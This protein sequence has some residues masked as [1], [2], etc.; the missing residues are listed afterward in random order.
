MVFGRRREE[1]AREEASRARSA[2][3]VAYVTLEQQW[4]TTG[5]EAQL[6]RGTLAPYDPYGQ[7]LEAEHQRTSAQL[8]ATT[9]AFLAAEQLHAPEAL[10]GRQALAE[11][12]ARWQSVHAQI[13]ATQQMV[14]GVVQLLGDIDVRRRW[15]EDVVPQLQTSLQDAAGAVTAAMDR[16]FRTADLEAVLTRSR[17]AAEEGARCLEQGRLWDAYDALG[18]AHADVGWV[19]STAWGLSRRHRELLARHAALTTRLADADR[20]AQ[21]AATTVNALRARY[22]ATVHQPVEQAPEQA[23]EAVEDARGALAEAAQ[24][25]SLEVQAY[26]DADA[27]LTRAETAIELVTDIAA[28]VAA[29]EEDV[30]AAVAEFPA[31]HAEAARD[32]AQAQAFVE[33]YAGHLDPSL[34]AA[35]VQAANVLADAER[36]GAAGRGDPF[37]VLQRLREVEG[38]S[39]QVLDVARTDVQRREA[40][41]HHARGAIRQA[42]R[43]VNRARSAAGLGLLGWKAQAKTAV[44]DA[45]RVLA[46]A[47]AVVQHDPARAERLAAEAAG[48]ATQVLTEDHRRRYGRPPPFL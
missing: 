25:A 13:A 9:S 14:Q 48:I 17:D 31:V 18:R 40:H 41:R 26:D 46:E 33:Q 11:A 23:A 7:R 39:T 27:A 37:E 47:E 28:A 3:R 29:V 2:A 35:L 24:A 34:R 45:D 44:A 32:L 10:G 4:T 19:T 16:G 20:L 21:R 15:C 8:A 38:Y 5:R 12:A 42:R 43:L 22:A 30:A 6:V 1:E 36:M